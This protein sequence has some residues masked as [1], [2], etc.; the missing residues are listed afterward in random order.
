M[1]LKAE[2]LPWGLKPVFPLN[3]A[4][5]ALDYTLQLGID[6]WVT[7]ECVFESDLR[8]HAMSR[9]TKLRLLVI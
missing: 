2:L 4:L 3:A 7:V 9:H 5:L 6:V 1:L 8:P